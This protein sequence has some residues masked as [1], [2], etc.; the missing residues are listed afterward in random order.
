M[1]GEPNDNVEVT[2]KKPFNEKIKW[3]LY[4]L[5]AV[6]LAWVLVK[7][8]QV[9]DNRDKRLAE[10]KAYQEFVEKCNAKW[11]GQPRVPIIGGGYLDATRLR[12]N[13]RRNVFNKTECGAETFT[14]GFYWTGSEII[15]EFVW[16]KRYRESNMTLQTPKDWIYM[17]AQYVLGYP[18]EVNEDGTYPGW[19]N[20]PGRHEPSGDVVKLKKSKLEVWMSGD[21]TYMKRKRPNSGVREMS[22]R[23]SDWPKDEGPPRF[24]GC[25]LNQDIMD[26]TRNEIEQL[27][28]LEQR[29]YCQ[30]DFPSFRFRGGRARV[31]ITVDSL[32][33]IYPA[34]RALH[35]YFSESV[36]EE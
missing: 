13:A 25:D 15:P 5:L 11:Q 3:I 2:Q 31:N 14:E 8:K 24:I 4:L 6:L 1:T 28:D 34:V 9:I 20:L 10:V 18:K 27:D 17:S 33:Q 32:A 26:M 21:G 19:E 12:W 36:S 29:I 35:E 23:F 30:M 16:S 7:C 22:F